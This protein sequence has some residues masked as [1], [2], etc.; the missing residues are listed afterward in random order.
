M[1][2]HR[3]LNAVSFDHFP[4]HGWSWV[5]LGNFTW[6]KGKEG[7][8]NRKERAPDQAGC[9]CL[10]PIWVEIIFSDRGRATAEKTCSLFQ[11]IAG[12]AS[13]LLRLLRVKQQD[14]LNIL[15]R[16]TLL[17]GRRWRTICVLLIF[18][19]NLLSHF[20]G[21]G[22]MCWFV[23]YDRLAGQIPLN[24]ISFYKHSLSL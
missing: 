5:S 10:R 1:V 11:N 14:Q 3:I 16:K 24:P 15:L 17:S 13:H 12:H 9:S 6:C 19:L 23:C 21:Q 2:Y 8:G 4:K 22:W 20:K 7:L 18:H